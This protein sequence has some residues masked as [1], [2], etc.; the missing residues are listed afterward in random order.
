MKLMDK[1]KAQ[2]AQ[3]AEKA[4]EGIRAGKA[5]LEEAQAKKKAEA[6]AAEGSAAEAPTA[7]GSAAAPDPGGD[8]T[9]D[10]L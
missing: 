3:A 1:V 6:P 8:F 5:K 10:G 2:A 4:Q 7:E 9:L